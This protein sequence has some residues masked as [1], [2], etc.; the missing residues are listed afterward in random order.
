MTPSTPETHTPTTPADQGQRLRM[1]YAEYLAWAHEDIHAEGANREVIV[2][3]PPKQ[4]PQIV[5][6]FLLRLLGQFIELFRLGVLLP[7]PFEMRA[8]PEGPAREPDLLFVAREPLARFTQAPLCGPG[9][10]V[11]EGIFDD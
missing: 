9:D 4:P 10:L 2:H 7:V 6:A 11:G 1:S 5:V 8:I 3:T